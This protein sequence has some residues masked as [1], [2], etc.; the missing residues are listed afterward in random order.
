MPFADRFNAAGYNSRSADRIALDME[1][2]F[3]LDGE[4]FEPL[5]DRPI[6]LTADAEASFVRV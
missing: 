3:T 4:L 6:V 1:S 2:P 5:P